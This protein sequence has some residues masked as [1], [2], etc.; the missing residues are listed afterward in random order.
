M[1]VY[2]EKIS[3]PVLFSLKWNFRQRQKYMG[4]V[5]KTC[6]QIFV[7]KTF[8]RREMCLVI[9]RCRKNL[10]ISTVNQIILCN[11]FEHLL[12]YLYDLDIFLYMPEIQ[13]NTLLN[14]LQ[15]FACFIFVVLLAS[16]KFKMKE[17][18]ITF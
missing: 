9:S 11:Y 17:V 15:V 1:S 13:M 5:L 10:V 8:S 2:L 12:V 14:L 7:L 3:L 6:E 16:Q 18:F 4:L